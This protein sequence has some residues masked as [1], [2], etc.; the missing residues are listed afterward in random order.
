MK[1]EKW[2][3]SIDALYDLIKAASTEREERMAKTMLR[4]LARSA[5][6][7]QQRLEDLKEETIETVT[8]LWHGYCK[9]QE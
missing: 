4:I 6:N 7:E 1:L 5:D 3:D 2:E 8:E 9:D